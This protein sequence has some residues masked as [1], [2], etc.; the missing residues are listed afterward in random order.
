MGAHGEILR[1]RKA[2]VW[3]GPASGRG[4]CSPLP[5]PPPLS[6]S[7]ENR[8]L[9]MFMSLLLLFFFSITMISQVIN[10]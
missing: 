10:Y 1:E 2:M 9:G 6:E 5:P 7:E 4:L 8:R 3:A